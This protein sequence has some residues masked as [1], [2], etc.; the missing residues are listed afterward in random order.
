MRTRCPACQTVFR[1]SAE[2]LRVREGKVRCGHCRHVFNAHNMLDSDDAVVPEVAAP[3]KGSGSIFVLEERPARDSGA[4]TPARAITDASTGDVESKRDSAPPAE[5]KAE[6]RSK[7]EGEAKADAEAAAKSERGPQ[8]AHAG[9]GIIP[10][11]LFI[12]KASNGHALLDA[13][14]DQANDTGAQR[15]REIQ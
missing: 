15:A 12:R 1:V 4:E 3:F 5:D 13:P 6:I 2:Q 8:S 14:V 7:A 9:G 11:A 10:T